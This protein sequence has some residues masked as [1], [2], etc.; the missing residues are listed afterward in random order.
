MNYAVYKDSGEILKVVRCSPSQIECEKKEGVSILEVEDNVDDSS[1]YVAGGQAVRKRGLSWELVDGDM[2][3][4][5]RGLP[6]GLEVVWDGQ[7]AF[8]DGGSL[9]LDHDVPGTYRLRI[10]GGIEYVDMILE[11]PID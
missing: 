6:E 2:E 5:I 4:E 1:H 7:T 9:F 11:V 8:T 10:Y 3:M